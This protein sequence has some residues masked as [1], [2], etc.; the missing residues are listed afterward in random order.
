MTEKV[1]K[2]EAPAKVNFTLELLGLMEDGYHR[3][4]TLMQTVSLSD[5]LTFKISPAR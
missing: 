3:V 2:V 1:V 4:K 5:T